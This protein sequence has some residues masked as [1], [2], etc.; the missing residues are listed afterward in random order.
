MH[1]KFNDK[2]KHINYI[3]GE[4]ILLTL[5][6]INMKKFL[7][8]LIAFAMINNTA[9]GWNDDASKKHTDNPHWVN[10]F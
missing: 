5:K 9:Y 2:Q 1:I 6:S 4:N 8:Y 10:I 7:L 3:S